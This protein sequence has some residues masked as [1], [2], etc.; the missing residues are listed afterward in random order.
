MSEENRDPSLVQYGRPLRKRSRG[1]KPQS[2][3]A[4]APA[5]GP[6]VGPV[7][8]GGA[9]T[10]VRAD[11]SAAPAGEVLGAPKPRPAPREPDDIDQN[12]SD[13][14]GFMARGIVDRPDR[15]QVR[16]L[17]AGDD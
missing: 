3:D 13:L 2:A 12:L 15:V 16:L 7:P 8:V 14:V 11:R 9:E 5:V 6:V 10:I 4:G 17:E 1:P